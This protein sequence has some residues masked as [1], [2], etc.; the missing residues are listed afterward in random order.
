MPVVQF[1]VF[2]L[3]GSVSLSESHCLILGNVGSNLVS[4]VTNEGIRCFGA[5][6]QVALS[7]E[8]RGDLWS[9]EVQSP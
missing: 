5:L 3:S 6:A 9:K 4:V 8:A 2:S 1:L 7:M